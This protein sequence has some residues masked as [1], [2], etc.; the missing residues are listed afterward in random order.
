M[1]F[2]FFEGEDDIMSEQKPI[3]T[4]LKENHVRHWQIAEEMGIH[5]NQLC[6]KLRHEP[7]EKLRNEI[8]KAMQS[9]LAKR[10]A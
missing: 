7:D 10:T 2:L 3:K 6:I 9:V 5:E 1:A 8:L 4:I